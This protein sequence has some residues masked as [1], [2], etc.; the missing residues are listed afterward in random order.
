M[1]RL[2]ISLD[3][4]LSEQFDEFIR[5]R[6]YTNRSEAMRDLIRDQL[7]TARLEK[8]GGGI[9]SPHSAIFTITTKAILPAVL[10]RYSTIITTLHCPAC[11]CTWTMITVSKW[12]FCEARFRA[13][14]ILPT[15]SWLR[16][17]FGMASYTWCRSKSGKKGI[18]TLPRRILT[19][20]R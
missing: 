9:A 1:E 19:A 14:K 8:G 17:A 13:S 15:L 20:I 3:N 6:G 5:A 10:P 16:A 4:Q 11:M 7:E 18:R 2:T 12:S